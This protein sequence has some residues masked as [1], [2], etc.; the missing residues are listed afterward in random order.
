MGTAWTEVTVGSPLYPHDSHSRMRWPEF[1]PIAS[2]CSA[3]T[4][5][6]AG[7]CEAKSCWKRAMPPRSRGTHCASV[8]GRWA[9]VPPL[10]WAVHRP[11]TQLLPRPTPVS[12]P[13]A[14]KTSHLPGARADFTEVDM[15][16]ILDPTGY[17]SL[18]RLG[19][20]TSCSFSGQEGRPALCLDPAP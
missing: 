15:S 2:L 9:W 12:C 10:P 18:L 6:V 17:Y 13:H 5:L 4:W 16:L 20:R 8:R 14:Y 7:S 11:R 19:L 1:V 3:T